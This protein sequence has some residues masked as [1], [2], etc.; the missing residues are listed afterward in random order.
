VTLAITTLNQHDKV[1]LRFQAKAMLGRSD[2][3]PA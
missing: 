1:V 3:P 2:P